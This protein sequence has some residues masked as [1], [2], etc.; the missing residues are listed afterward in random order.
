MA[1]VSQTWVTKCNEV[2]SPISAHNPYKEL[3]CEIPMETISSIILR[4]AQQRPRDLLYITADGS[5]TF[6]RQELTEMCRSFAKALIAKGHEPFDGGE[7][8]L[9]RST[10]SCLPLRAV[11]PRYSVSLEWN[12]S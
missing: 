12:Q 5:R 2:R 1:K 3:A 6:D 9:L 11:H 10:T 4:N 7:V 8:S